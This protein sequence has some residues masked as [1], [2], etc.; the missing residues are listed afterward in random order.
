MSTLARPATEDS[1]P[2]F[3]AATASSM[4]ASS[5]NSP[6]AAMSGLRSCTREMASFTRST[7]LPA[8]EPQVE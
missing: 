8:P 5:W 2:T 6:S 7:E 1:R 3:L 4:A